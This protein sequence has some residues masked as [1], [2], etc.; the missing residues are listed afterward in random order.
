MFTRFITYRVN[1]EWLPVLRK[2]VPL[3]SRARFYRPDN[4]GEYNRPPRGSATRT[5]SLRLSYNVEHRYC[6]RNAKR[7]RYAN[8]DV[9]TLVID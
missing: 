9:T 6:P 5:I 8:D 4:G 7:E 2:L 3:N 1:A